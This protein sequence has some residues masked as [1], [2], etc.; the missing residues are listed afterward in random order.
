MTEKPRI[1]V[2]EDDLGI[3]TGVSMNL[4][5]EGYEVIQAQDGKSG[6]AK[7][8]DERPDL[9]LLDVM[10]PQMNG[11]EVLKELRE[12]GIAT[13]VVV[14]SA[15]GM[16]MDK[17]S[18]LDLGA[19]DY[20]VKP[21]ALQELLA[22]IRAVLRRKGT[23]REDPNL[24]FDDVVVNLSAK[25]VRKAGQDPG[26]TAQELKLLLHLCEHPKK[27]Y[28]REELLQA[29]WG[30][31]YEGTARTVDNFISQLRQKLETNPDEPKH[32]VTVRGQGYRF[33]P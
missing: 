25:T 33:D 9:I 15:K 20:V 16:E 17:I 30:Y 11:F 32:F 8:I 19:D 10:L 29:A 18:G 24:K 28:S 4:N 2:V 22:R 23:I 1:L 13:P 21:F 27:A 31:G 14:V 5:F 6:L 12:R 3:L 7:A 26:L